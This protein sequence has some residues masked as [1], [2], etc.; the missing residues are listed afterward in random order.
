MTRPVRTAAETLTIEEH[1]A[2]FEYLYDEVEPWAWNRLSMKL[3]AIQARRARI[4]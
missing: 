2:W 1:D 3:R 4:A